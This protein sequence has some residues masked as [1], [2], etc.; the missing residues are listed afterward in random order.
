MNEREKRKRVRRRKRE[1]RKRRRKGG[2]KEEFHGQMTIMC[3]EP[4]IMINPII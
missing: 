3:H 4:E 2:Q 1:E